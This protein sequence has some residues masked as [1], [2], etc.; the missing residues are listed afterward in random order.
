MNT[1]QLSESATTRFKECLKTLDKYK[2]LGGV[3]TFI[4]DMEGLLQFYSNGIGYEY[5]KL[6]PIAEISTD[7]LLKEIKRRIEYH[8]G[9][10]A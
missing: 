1:Y 3:K 5:P 9:P 4:E 7:D 2:S 8:G 10:T 6:P